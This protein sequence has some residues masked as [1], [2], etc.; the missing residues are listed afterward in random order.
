MYVEDQSDRGLPTLT[1]FLPPEAYS[2]SP[3]V[4]VAQ[5][6]PTLLWPDAVVAFFYSLLWIII[7]CRYYTKPTTLGVGYV[8][9]SRLF[10]YYNLSPP[11]R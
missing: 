11:L 2:E 3:L 10:T 7:V 5:V 1:V 9:L 4:A 8:N 6:C